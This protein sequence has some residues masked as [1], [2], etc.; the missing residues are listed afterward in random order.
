MEANIINTINAYSVTLLQIAWGDS[1][2][3]GCYSNRSNN[4][5]T[6]Q[7]GETRAEQGMDKYG[8]KLSHIIAISKQ[9]IHLQVANPL[10]IAQ[11]TFFIFA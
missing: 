4:K 7:K 1:G 3:M 5:I 9:A 2:E 6:Q 10:E 8:E 11:I